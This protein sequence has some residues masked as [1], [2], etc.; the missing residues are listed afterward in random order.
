MRAAM[1]I[2]FFVPSTEPN[3]RASTS[4]QTGGNLP[5]AYRGRVNEFGH[6]V[7]D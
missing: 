6:F 5:T 2:Y 1:Q 4:D 3:V 7:I